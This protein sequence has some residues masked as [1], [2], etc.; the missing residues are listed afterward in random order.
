MIRTFA[1][2]VV[3]A[4]LG[5][6]TP[7]ASAAQQASQPRAYRVIV[8]VDNPVG[9]I[10]ESELAQLFLRKTQAWRHNGQQILPVDQN[11]GSPVRAAFVREVYRKDEGAL[12]AYWRQMIFSGKAVPPPT[13][14]SDAAV[15]EYVRRYPNAIGYV[16]AS[17]QVP[18]DLKLV[19][20]TQ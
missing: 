11:E 13:E 9:L 14:G 19:T 16:S 20:V 8:N 15:M 2:F 10:T 5:A 3:A 6:V 7:R 17:A 12:K 18:A 4:A 1:V